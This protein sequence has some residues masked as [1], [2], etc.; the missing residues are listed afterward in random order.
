M[1]KNASGLA[2]CTREESVSVCTDAGEQM[3]IPVRTVTGEQYKVLS[4]E[5]S[6]KLIEVRITKHLES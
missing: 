4:E 1:I 3:H 6:L 5:D 2:L